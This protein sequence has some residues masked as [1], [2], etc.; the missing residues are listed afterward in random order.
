MLDNDQLETLVLK[1]ESSIRR[2]RRIVDWMKTVV[3]REARILQSAEN[4]K[5]PRGDSQNSAHSSNN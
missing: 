5:G 3:E 2:A 4:L 1:G